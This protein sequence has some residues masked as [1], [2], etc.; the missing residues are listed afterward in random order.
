MK[1]GFYSIMAAQFFSSL[2]DSALLIAAI[3]LLKD[4]H[5]QNWMTPLLKLFFVLSYVVLAAFVGAFADSRPKG[6]VMFVTNTIKIVGCI[7][8]MVGA[9]PLLA[10]GIVGF[11]AAAYSPAKYGILTELLPPERLV[12]ANGW[13]EGTTV[14]SIILGTVLGGALIS[15]H[16]AVHILRHHIPFVATP[17]EA[18]MLVI[19]GIYVIAALFNLRIPDTGARYPRQEH[20]PI[21]LVTDF[22]ECFLTLWRD[23]LGQISLAVTTLF[24]GAGAT[25]QFIVLKWAEVSLGMSL[26][27]G[28][29]LQA[30][31]ALGVAFGA[32]AAAAKV[33]LKKS[34]TVLPVGVLMG[35]AVMLMAFYTRHLIPANWGLYF[36]RVHVPGYLIIAYLFLMIVG[37]LSGFF[38]VPMNALLQH[39]GHVLLSAG[40]S[41]AVQ[42]FNENLSVLIMLCLYAVLVW[43]DVPVSIVIVLFGTFVCLMMW[44]V[45]RRHQANQRAFDAVALIGEVKH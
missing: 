4:L 43:L 22:A 27:E 32:M 33:P 20:G 41:I 28:A 14:A 15:P 19:V 16:I 23:K 3:A 35:I 30:V 40:H 1:K 24:W 11:G 45:M 7:V 5:A 12:A 2:A 10:Y 18:A 39:R 9:H 13:I 37:A 17:A 8:M 26:S 42:N 44:V 31:V 36:G 25:L 34:L 6:R 21:K 38:V 29:I